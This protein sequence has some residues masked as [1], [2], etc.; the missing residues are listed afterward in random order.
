MNTRQVAGQET[1]N[2]RLRSHQGSICLD[3]WENDPDA[4]P[5]EASFRF[6]V[7]YEL[8]SMAEAQAI[9]QR[10]L[11]T[12]NVHH[13]VPSQS[14]TVTPIHLQTLAGSSS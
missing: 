7:T 9:L 2:Y 11:M 1:L 3:L 13:A 10:Y 12:N 8:Q 14:Q 6:F 5:E 4:P